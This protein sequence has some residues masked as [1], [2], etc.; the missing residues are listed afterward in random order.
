MPRWSPNRK[1]IAFSAQVP[2]K[3]WKNHL[4]S[5]EGGIPKQ[6]V[7]GQRNEDGPS[8]SPDGNSVAFGY[9]IFLEPENSGPFTIQVV[10]VRTRQVTTLPGS[11]GLYS[12]SWSP[13]GAYVAAETGD[14]QELLLFDTASGKW[15][16]LAKFPLD[17]YEWSHDEKY[18]YVKGEPSAVFRIRVSDHQIERVVD[19][20][21]FRL[22]TGAIGPW[23]GLAPDDSPLVVHDV[24]TQEIYALDWVAP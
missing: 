20:E 14:D 13:N 6:I 9:I 5:S 16:Q 4:I 3:P 2:G 12:V 18:I 24:G 11:E 23:A 17:Y 1:Q 10:N 15:T 21:R 7:P 22:A 8:W 19:L